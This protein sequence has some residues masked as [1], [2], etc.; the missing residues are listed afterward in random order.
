MISG[1]IGNGT[2]SDSWLEATAQE[3]VQARIDAGETIGD[4]DT[5]MEAARTQIA[6]E[7]YGGGVQKRTLPLEVTPTF[8][9]GGL[10]SRT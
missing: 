1:I 4:L 3:R 10:I 9:P 2:L 7:M 6:E 8:G 5:E